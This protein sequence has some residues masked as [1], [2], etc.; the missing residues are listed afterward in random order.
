MEMMAPKSKGSLS[1]ES[2]SKMEGEQITAGL[3]LKRKGR[4]TIQNRTTDIKERRRVQEIGSF[5]NSQG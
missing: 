3:N 4:D 5:S 2:F 1:N